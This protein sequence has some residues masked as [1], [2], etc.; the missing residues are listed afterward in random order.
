MMKS[1]LEVLGLDDV[2]HAQLLHS[3]PW[4]ANVWVN[5]VLLGLAENRFTGLNFVLKEEV[6]AYARCPKSTVVIENLGAVLVLQNAFTPQASSAERL[7][8]NKLY[9]ALF[10]KTTTCGQ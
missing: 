5:E 2:F 3:M 6:L 9:I 4:I 7:V 10:V 1:D 8:G